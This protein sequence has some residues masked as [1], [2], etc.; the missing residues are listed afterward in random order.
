MTVALLGPNGVDSVFLA[1]PNNKSKSIDASD[2]ALD[3]FVKSRIGSAGVLG[4][5]N[6]IVDGRFDFWYEAVTQSG[7]GYGSDT[8]WQ[9]NHSGSTKT[10]TAQPL[11]LGVDLPSIDVPTA[12]NFSRTVVSSVAGAGNSVTKSHKIEGVNTCAGKIITLSFYAKADATKPLGVSMVQNFG[13]GG[14]SP[15]YIAG[16][17]VPL[18]SGWARYSL[19]FQLPSMSGKTIGTDSSLQVV[20]WFDGGSTVVGT[21]NIS[22]MVQQSGTFDLACVQLEEGT[23]ATP[24]EELP[25]EVSQQRVNRYWERLNFAVTAYSAYSSFWFKTVKREI[26]VLTLVSGSLSGTTIVCSSFLDSLYQGVAASAASSLVYYVD[27]RL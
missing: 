9:N 3:S 1:N 18:S 20:F 7:I 6:K 8:M 22:S 11:V 14:S 10:H 16:Q 12:K 19:Q 21:Y 5:R 2:L 15:V 17:L 25:I 27:A 23:V 4:F 24:F 26:P 13:S